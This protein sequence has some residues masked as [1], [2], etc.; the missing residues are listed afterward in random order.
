MPLAHILTLKKCVGLSFY[1][2]CVYCF[3]FLQQGL[4]FDERTLPRAKAIF[5]FRPLPENEELYPKEASDCYRSAFELLSVLTTEL[6]AKRNQGLLLLGRSILSL[7]DPPSKASLDPSGLKSSL[8]LRSTTKT[9]AGRLSPFQT[10][11]SKTSP[12]QFKM[13]CLSSSVPTLDVSSRP[14]AMLPVINTFF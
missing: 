10:Q 8:S 12:I 3:F 9:T 7:T 1:L 2:L 11:S 5:E 4:G 13:Q 14:L 6:E